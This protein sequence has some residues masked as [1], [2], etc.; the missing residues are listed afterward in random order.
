MAYL[1]LTLGIA[2]Y[3]LG[4]GGLALRR[5]HNLETQALDMGYADQVTWN[6]LHGRPFRFTVFRGQVG[7]ELGRPLAFGP[8]ADRD[9]LLAYHVELLYLPISLLYLIHAGPE[10]LIVLLTGVLAAG[11]LPAYWLAHRQL[12]HRGAALV[13]GAAYLL[14]PAIQAANLSD[15]HAV[16]LTGS[17]LLFALYFL[18]EQ[19]YR[20]FVIPAAIC[21]AAKEEVGIVVGLMGLYAWWAHGQRRLGLAVAGLS[22][23]WVALCFLVI[24][25]HFNGGAPSLFTARYVD[26]VRHVRAFPASLLAGTPIPPLPEYTRRYVVHLRGGTGFLALL[27]PAPLALA[28]PIVAINGLSSSTWQHGGGAHYSAEIVPAVLL[29][30][31]IGTRRLATWLGPRLA[32]PPPRVAG[33]IAVVVLAAAVAETHRHGI[34]WPASRASWPAPTERMARL[35]PLLARIPPG[36]A[37]SA[38]SNVFPHLS[39]RETIYVFPTVDD[40]EYVLIDVAGTSGPLYPDDLFSEVATLLRATR[41]ELLTAD[42]GFLLFRRR[43]L[44]PGVRPAVGVPDAGPPPPFFDFARAP[45]DERYTPAAALFGDDV[46]LVGYRLEPQPEV[47]YSVRHATP[48]F[49]FRAARAITRAYRLTTYIV[50]PHGPPRFYD[51]GNATQLW[52]PSYSWRPGEIVAVRYPPIAFTPGDRIGVG[53]QLGMDATAPRLT[54]TSR[55][56]TLLDGGRVVLLGTLP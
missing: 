49:Y 22:F 24:M 41:F 11:A 26:A 6:L 9:S 42:T 3:A 16:S 1:V 2:A 31:I 29:A 13:F 39:T 51:D 33:G 47:S 52:Y 40:A 7:A 18:L 44:A 46:E 38:Q 27:A 25:P 19:R 55:D 15:F 50:G 12:R 36:A 30:A 48:I 34:L 53:V 35:R 54:A 21:V 17:L 37:V 10:T 23:T 56:A 28:A 45:A 32:L 20:S 14:S 43:N 8:G 4:A 5:H